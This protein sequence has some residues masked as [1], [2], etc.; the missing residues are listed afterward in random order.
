M[1]PSCCRPTTYL[2]AF[3]TPLVRDLGLAAE[4][5]FRLEGERII[6]W[7]D[8]KPDHAHTHCLIFRN[9]L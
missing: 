2:A 5:H 3:Y 1:H 7:T 6:A 9:A 8:A 4:R